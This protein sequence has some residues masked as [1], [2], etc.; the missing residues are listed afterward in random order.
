[1]KAVPPTT[2]TKNMRDAL[3]DVLEEANQVQ[4]VVMCRDKEGRL[5]FLT[6]NCPTK[7]E[8]AGLLHYGQQFNDFQIYSELEK[9]K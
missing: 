8:T 4:A 2:K 9:A 1:M 5:S 7:I 6:F 3:N